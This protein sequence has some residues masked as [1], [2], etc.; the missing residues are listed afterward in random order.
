MRQQEAQTK[1]TQ[2]SEEAQRLQLQALQRR[3]DGMVTSSPPPT[4]A[5]DAHASLLAHLRTRDARPSSEAQL[6]GG[7]KG[8]LEFLQEFELEV[9]R[10]PGITEGEV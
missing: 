4:P 3:V 5:N 6:W 7:D 2:A 1:A 10:I 9:E 8:V